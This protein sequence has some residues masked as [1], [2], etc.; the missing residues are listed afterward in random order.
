MS[1]GKRDT[2][3][4]ESEAKS[5]AYTVVTPFY[6]SKKTLAR[7]IQAIQQLDPP[8]QA[9]YMVDDASTDRAAELAWHFDGVTVIV[10]DRNG[11]Q[12]RARN[13]GAAKAE[14]QKIKAGKCHCTYECSMSPN[15]LFNPK[16]YPQ[17]GKAFI[18]QNLG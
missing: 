5:P 9:I 1:A 16:M 6:N 3:L 7:T 15:I 8:P 12:S 14:R 4:T 17:L 10:L 11:G 18:R 2:L 13:V